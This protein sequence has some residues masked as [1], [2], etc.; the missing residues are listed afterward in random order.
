MDCENSDKS[1]LISIHTMKSETNKNK[2]K[3][4]KKAARPKSCNKKTTKLPIKIDRRIYRMLVVHV[5]ITQ[6]W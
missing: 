2:T 4:K 6:I 3:T 1:Y 5:Q